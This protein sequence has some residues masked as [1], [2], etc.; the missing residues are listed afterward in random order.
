[1][2]IVTP[3]RLSQYIGVAPFHRPPGIVIAWPL[4]V[5]QHCNQTPLGQVVHP[6]TLV[7]IHKA[8]QVLIQDSIHSSCLPM[9]LK[10][11][12]CVE[13]QVGFNLHE[14]VF[15]PSNHPHPISPLFNPSIQFFFLARPS[16]CN[17]VVHPARGQTS[18]LDGGA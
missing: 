14:D 17:L 5:W 8:L 18:M 9:Y 1:V 15:Q 11:E 13:G 4:S 10:M 6:I 3:Q 16:S 2:F 7:Y 12:R